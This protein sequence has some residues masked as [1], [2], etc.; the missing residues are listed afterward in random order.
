MRFAMLVLVLCTFAGTAVADD[1]TYTQKGEVIEIHDPPIKP[2]PL[3]FKPNK[4]PPYSDAAI[5]SDAWTKAWM[6]LDVSEAG[7]VTRVK[8]LNRPGYDLERIAISESFKLRFDPARD[9][10]GN[11]V[12]VY[13]VWQIEWPS[14]WWL[15]DFVG[16]RSAMPPIVGFPPRRLDASVPCK[17]SGPMRL[18]SLHPAYKDCSKPDLS[19]A[20]VEPWIAPPSPAPK[21][22]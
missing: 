20:S 19:K 3:N 2:K 22:S 14:A 11:P 7:Q 15:S 9:G 13:V 10:R 4:A 18:E 1:P 8:F 21:R 6:L 17:G 12:R 16:T 5:L